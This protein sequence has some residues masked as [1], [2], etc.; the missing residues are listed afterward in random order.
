M[1]WLRRAVGVIGG[2][3]K[4]TK[5]YLALDLACLRNERLGHLLEHLAAQGRIIHADHLWRVP[6]P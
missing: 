4:T 6:F 5:T 1:L 3:P 2:P